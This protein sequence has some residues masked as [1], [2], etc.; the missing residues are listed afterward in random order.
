[1]GADWTAPA[2]HPSSDAEANLMPGYILVVDDE[3][4]VR[5]VIAE[6]L[7]L[8]GFEV[9]EARNG[10]EA[11]DSIK[12][13]LPDLIITDVLMPQMDGFALCQ[14]IRQMPEP[15]NRLPVILLTALDT[16]LG[17]QV[18]QELGANLYLTKPFSPSALRERV[19]E[20]LMAAGTPF[21]ERG[22]R[23]SNAG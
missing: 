9:R 13:D 19:R 5:T 15:I 3:D 10:K 17:R 18:G 8:D 22:D 11:L 21:R 7:R 6:S 20:L 1:M 4:A 16:P 14:A 23:H 12:A 2:Q